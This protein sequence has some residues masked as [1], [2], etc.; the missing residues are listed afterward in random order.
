MFPQRTRRQFVRSLPC[1]PGGEPQLPVDLRQHCWRPDMPL[2][3]STEAKWENLR[4]EQ[5]NKKFVPPGVTDRGSI[6]HPA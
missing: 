2:P 3:S 1:Q 6:N 5:K 4:Q